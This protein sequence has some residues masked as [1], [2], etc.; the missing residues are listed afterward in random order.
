ME[1]THF[2]ALLPPN[3]VHNWTLVTRL[4]DM[5]TRAEQLFGARDHSWTILGIEFGGNS[6]QIWYAGDADT[7]HVVIQ[8]SRSRLNN[9]SLACY[10]LAHECIHLLSPSGGN[11][12]PTLEEGLA[13][14]FA[15]DYVLERFGFIHDSGMESYRQAAAL[16]RKLLVIEPDAVKRLRAV[17]PS[18]TNMSSAT[19]EMAQLHVPEP[20]RHALIH[21]F[22]RG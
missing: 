18:F 2:Q 1:P 12:V 14:V 5:L 13:T 16:V 10:E 11:V 22:L 20:L 17:E 8:L 6:P 9:T 4:G 15:E 7:K 19:F 3:T 21:P